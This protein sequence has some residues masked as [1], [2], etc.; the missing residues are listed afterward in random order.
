MLIAI[1][2]IPQRNTIVY[3]TQSIDQSTGSSLVIDD[4]VLKTDET[5]LA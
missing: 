4:F 5:L 1:N 3:A 2:S